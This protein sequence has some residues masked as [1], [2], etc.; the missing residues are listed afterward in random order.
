MRIDPAASVFADP[1]LTN[2]YAFVTLPLV[3]ADGT[4]EALTQRDLLDQLAFDIIATRLS[5]DALVG[6]APFRSAAAT[7]SS[8]VRPLDAPEISVEVAGD[9]VEASVTAILDEYERVRRFGV[10]DAEVA[11]AVDTVRSR[12]QAAIDGQGSRQD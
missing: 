12:N 3:R 2:G 10:T 5:D 8:Y 1:D 7:S 6:D 9:G 11:R 4:L